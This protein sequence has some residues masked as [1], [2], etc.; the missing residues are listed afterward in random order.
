L[1]ASLHHQAQIAKSEVERLPMEKQRLDLEQLRQQADKEEKEAVRQLRVLMAEVGGDFEFISSRGD[2]RGSPQGIRRD[3]AMAVLLSKLALVRSRSDSLSDLNDIK[4]LI[5]L[6]NSAQELLAMH[7]VGRDPLQVARSKWRE[8]EAWM[9]AV[10]NMKQEVKP[11]SSVVSQASTSS[12]PSQSELA[13]MQRKLEDDLAKLKKRVQALVDGL[14]VEVAVSGV[15][16][17]ELSELATMDDLR[18]DKKN[19]RCTLFTKYWEEVAVTKRSL[20]PDLTGGHDPQPRL[21]QQMDSALADLRHWQD[22]Y[23]EHEQRLQR[24]ASYLAAGRLSTAKMSR[25]KLGQVKFAGLNYQPV[26]D[27][28]TLEST[29]KE[30]ERAKQGKAAQLINEIGA[31]YPK[32]GAHTELMQE[33]SKYQARVARKKRQA[34]ILALFMLGLITFAGKVVVDGQRQA[35][36]ERLA[37]E[38]IANEAKVRLSTDVRSGVVGGKLDIPLSGSVSTQLCFIPSGSFTM[39]RPSGEEGHSS[40]ERQVE[41]TVSQPF[42]LAKTE[43]TQAQ[44][45]AVMGSNTS[46]FK[47]DQL[48]V[49]N[50]SWEDTQSFITKINDRHLL[51]QGWKFALPTEAQWEYACRAGEKGPYSGGSLDEVGWYGDNS[52]RKTHEVGQKKPNAWGL[53]DMHGNVYE[54][55]ADW[56]DSTLNGGV[57]PEGPESGD[58]RVNRGGCCFHYPSNC[59]AADRSRNTPEFRG[60]YVG[61]RLALVPSK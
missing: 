51:P 14:P 34:L 1:E 6:E 4:E 44:W 21:V 36:A 56:Y 41:V 26:T 52:D 13:E 54:W 49:E 50:I 30:L 47:V 3:Y 61:F 16:L 39:G 11:Q 23:T 24:L 42:W 38:R 15:I 53:Q 9:Q 31:K 45:E 43:V 10:E 48:P 7:F 20:Q 5:S 18:E 12:L 46:H 35:E 29:L 8:I 32:A 40:D 25:R 33:L 58:G 59:R 57:D 37:F 55:C 60:A 19:Y 28:K 17:S 2:F 27:L 22:R